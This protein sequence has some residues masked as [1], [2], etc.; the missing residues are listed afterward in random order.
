MAAK[1]PEADKTATQPPAGPPAPAASNAQEIEP[2]LYYLKDKDGK[3]QPVPN[4]S[5][6]DFMKSYR[7]MHQLEKPEEA[8]PKY[9]L[10]DL[11][12]NGE[13][14]KDRADLTLQFKILTLSPDWVR[15]PLRLNKTALRQAVDIS[16]GGEQFVQYEEG[17]GYVAWIKAKENSEQ[18]LTLKLSTNVTP[19]HRAG[20]MD[21]SLPRAPTAKL[22]LRVPLAKA[23]GTVSEGATLSSA[24]PAGDKQTEFTIFGVNGDFQLTWREPE[25][26]ALE[27]PVTLE[28]SGALLVKLDERSIATD[29]T[30]TVR[31][32]NGEFDHLQ[33]K[34]PTDVRVQPPSATGYKFESEV[35]ED[36]TLINVTLE[37]KTAGPLEI[38]FSTERDYDPTKKDAW[39]DLSLAQVVGAPRQFGNLAV[40]VPNGWQLL[41]GNQQGFRQ[42]EDLPEALHRK[43]VVAGFE[44][45]C[46]PGKPCALPVRVVK[47]K[48][49][50]H[51]EPDYAFSVSADQVQL[52]GKLRYSI[53]GA[54][55]SKLEVDG[56][57]WELDEVGPKTAV[58]AELALATESGP[59]EIPLL[60]AASGDLELTFRAHR[61]IPPNA[62]TVEWSLPQPLADVVGPANVS[63]AVA[64]NV[65]L[66]PTASAIVGLT[67]QLNGSAAGGMTGSGTSASGTSASG[68]PASGTSAG[69]APASGTALTG[70]GTKLNEHQQGLLYYRGEVPQA[71][72]AA[73]FQ[74]HSQAIQAQVFSHVALNFATIQIEQRI[75]YQINY[76]GAD[77]LTLVAPKTLGANG[78]LEFYWD[79]QKLVAPAARDQADSALAQFSVQ[80]PKAKLGRGE[81][82]IKY[83]LPMEKLV[84]DA[85]VLVSIPLFMPSDADL[86]TNELTTRMATGIH[87]EIRGEPWTA[88]SKAG[89]GGAV[90]PDHFIAT[91]P[92]THADFQ[93]SPDD[94]R[95]GQQV[96][97]ERAW[98]QTWLTPAQRQ[99]RAV[100]QFHTSGGQLHLSLPVGVIPS[101]VEVLLDSV[102]VPPVVAPDAGLSIEVPPGLESSEHVVELRYRF[103]DHRLGKGKQ[104]LD[105]P[106][107][108]RE[109]WIRRS[110]WQLILPKDEHLLVAPAD[111]TSEN[112]W[113]WRGFYWERTPAL[114][115]LALETWCGATHLPAPAEATNRYLFSALEPTA[116]VEVMTAGRALL[117][118]GA[119][120]IA[121]AAGLA[122]LYLK[123]LRRPIVWFAGGALLLVTGLLMPETM[124]L[125]AQA[126][127]MG[128]L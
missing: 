61:R 15:V 94:S 72:F 55:V 80:L 125:V 28:S 93:V 114:E 25:S 52:E 24:Q 122:L 54:K 79:G 127:G 35:T 37:K 86:L 64:D 49:R 33:L 115:Q 82:T 12:I 51:V 111:W 26:R 87:A 4:F 77:R 113:G 57:G 56:S 30:Y 76:V 36:A 59:W 21:I 34:L 128:I 42:I 50:L 83:S 102:Q 17:T 97:V 45:T 101:E 39:I 81:L 106:R 66:T 96:I 126:A 88:N 110:Y 62:A 44:Y 63:I 91:K 109:V 11:S 123:V 112:V 107:V 104:T 69:G 119:S 5:F 29:A 100:F 2:K 20:R 9:S 85:I 46:L 27:M 41:V 10:Q 120:L 3:L 78:S 31:S 38:H 90:G 58:D 108:G 32:L 121:L 23:V 16:G 68:T 124:W 40:Q 103:A 53:R 14:H 74:V 60:A 116:S 70:P 48:T 6:E 89:P 22:V 47:R 105:F 92:A 1:S 71:K 95:E 75:Q 43:D 7:L 67:R 73:E 84:P 117:V 65:E 19:L 13:V 18:T 99:D 98:F 118:C 8:K